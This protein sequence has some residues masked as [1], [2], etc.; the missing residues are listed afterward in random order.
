MS[1]GSFKSEGKTNG[2]V[3]G[4]YSFS[5][6]TIEIYILLMLLSWFWFTYLVR[7]DLHANFIQ[8]KVIRLGHLLS[9]SKDSARIRRHAAT[10]TS[11][12]VCSLTCSWAAFLWS[13]EHMRGNI[14]TGRCATLSWGTS[15]T[16]GQG[17]TRLERLNTDKTLIFT[18]HLGRPT[19]QMAQWAL[20][21]CPI[22]EDY[23]GDFDWKPYA[24][25][26]NECYTTTLD[27]P[28]FQLVRARP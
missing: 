5:F 19:I 3:W 10:P 21:A 28:R 20:H 17:R 13:L 12:G 25:F 2:F 14:S 18:P 1:T 27:R 6:L 24:R 15:E 9:D 26:R 23:K 22:W 4:H 8:G 16:A 11:R 7:H